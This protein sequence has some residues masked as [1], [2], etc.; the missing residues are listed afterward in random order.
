M[1]HQQDRALQSTQRI[2]HEV[3]LFRIQQLLDQSK[4]GKLF[5]RMIRREIRTAAQLREEQRLH[6]EREADL[7][8]QIKR[9]KDKRPF[10]GHYQKIPAKVS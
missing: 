8:H 2:N 7:L 10:I 4:G 1:K 3:Q 9:L 6:T 5:T